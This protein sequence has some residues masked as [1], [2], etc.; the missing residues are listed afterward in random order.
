MEFVIQ[1][2]P[3]EPTVATCQGMRYRLV[4][5]EIQD[6]DG[7]TLGHYQR[8]ARSPLDPPV[9]ES[10]D[11]AFWQQGAV[12]AIFTRGVS[13]QPEF[14]LTYGDQTM[15]IRPSNYYICEEL[16]ARTVLAWYPEGQCVYTIDD[17]IDPVSALFLFRML[18]TIDE[19]A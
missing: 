17:A 15:C 18:E 16:H 13:P 19:D 5:S 11:Y 7:T 3:P 12:A 10:I 6:N 2:R 1:R 14:W 4:G 9:P 8:C